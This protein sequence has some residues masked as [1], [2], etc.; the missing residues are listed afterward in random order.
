MNRLVSAA[1]LAVGM[2][3]SQEANAGVFAECGGSKGY[4]YFYPGPFAKEGDTGFSEDAISKGSFSIVSIEDRFDVIFTDASGSIQS[5]LSQGA[6]VI[7]VGSVREEGRLVILVNYPKSTIEIYSYHGLS[8]T[9][10]LLQH[11]YS[12]II[13]SSKLLVSRCK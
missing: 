11:K 3:T 10:T 2:L 6:T 4:A 7:P 12:G 13:S 9:L 1:V 8:K 5:S